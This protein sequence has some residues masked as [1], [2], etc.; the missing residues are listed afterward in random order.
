MEKRKLDEGDR[1]GGEGLMGVFD[2]RYI[3][4]E[5]TGDRA[6]QK[7]VGTKALPRSVPGMSGEQQGSQCV[8][9]GTIES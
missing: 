3:G 2:W 1:K 7:R 6:V 8:S 4:M 9:Q 5:G